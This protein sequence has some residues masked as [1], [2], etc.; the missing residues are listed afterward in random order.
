[1]KKQTFSTWFNESPAYETDLGAAFSGDSRDLLAQMPNESISL[2]VT[3]PPFALL[4][5]KEY[6]NK[7]QNEYVEWLGSF[8]ELEPIR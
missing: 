6:G 5:K 2:V 4:R 7:E 8:A 1:M 3:S